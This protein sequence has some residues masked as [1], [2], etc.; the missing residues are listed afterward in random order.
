MSGR[1]AEGRGRKNRV[2]APN[3]NINLLSPP[4]EEMLGEGLIA[5]GW[6]QDM[7]E[8]YGAKGFGREQRAVT[9]DLWTPGGFIGDGCVVRK[10]PKLTWGRGSH[11]MLMSGA[12]GG[13]IWA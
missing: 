5:S 2:E 3:R 12:E 7:G 13:D 4:M 11:S 6:K 8:Q 10:G 9:V 1:I